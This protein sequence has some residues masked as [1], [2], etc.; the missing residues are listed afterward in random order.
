MSVASHD[1]SGAV[2]SAS[3]VTCEGKRV[4]AARV[5]QLFRRG[6]RF[7]HR[8]PLRGAARPA[9]HCAN[10]AGEVEV[11][12]AAM[13]CGRRRRWAD[14][15]ACFGGVLGQAVGVGERGEDFTIS[16]RQT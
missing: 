9:D 3:S 2:G 5:H 4:C 1:P 7:C 16:F 11:T 8:C 15:A 14:G 13:C 10:V 6:A 12:P